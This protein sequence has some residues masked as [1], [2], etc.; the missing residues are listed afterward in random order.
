[1]TF[2]TLGHKHVSIVLSV[3]LCLFLLNLPVSAVE[4]GHGSSGGHGDYGHKDMAAMG[5]GSFHHGTY[6]KGHGYGHSGDSYGRYGFGS[7]MGPHQAANQ[8]IQHI[9]RFK[10]A[11]AITDEQEH[12]LRSIGTTY[13]KTKIKMK[14]E[15]ELANLDLHDLLR[16]DQASLS[17][18][19]S[20]LKNV[21]E[22]KANLL[23]ASIKAKR[24]AKGVLTDEQ[25]QRMKAV[26][27]RIKQYGSGSMSQGHPGGYKHHGES[28]E[29]QS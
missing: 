9:L 1:M 22:L 12:K 5:H 14:A 10:E 29:K 21:H 8:Y 18:I 27:D 11:M 3:F 20:K 6:A 19:E 4:Y 15:V 17:D 2:P 16:N 24:D 25:R 13:E 7:H 28:K 26:H 23:M